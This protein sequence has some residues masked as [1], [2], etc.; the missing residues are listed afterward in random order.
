MLNGK[1]T[2]KLTELSNRASNLNIPWH[3]VHD[4]GHTEIPSGSTTV[5]ACFGYEEDVNK[6]TGSLRLLK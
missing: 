1:N 5:F 6:V 3:L 2:E 4:A